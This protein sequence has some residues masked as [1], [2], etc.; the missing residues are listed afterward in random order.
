MQIFFS[1]LHALEQYTFS[2]DNIPQDDACQHCAAANQWVSHGY[3]YKQRS[4]A[5]REVVGK[6]LLCGKR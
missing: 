2:V 3:V 4:M 1:S 6:R 5:K